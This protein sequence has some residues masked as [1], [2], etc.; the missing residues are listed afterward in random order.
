MQAILIILFLIIINNYLVII[1][2]FVGDS[3]ITLL[4]LAARYKD[5][6]TRMC[7]AV[8]AIKRT[9]RR[10]FPSRA[11]LSPRLVGAV[12]FFTSRI[13]QDPHAALAFISPIS[14]PVSV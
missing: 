1:S 5:V 11:R 9:P 12:L 13:R 8:V 6:H 4:K 3:R 2:L 7:D 14:A 10:F